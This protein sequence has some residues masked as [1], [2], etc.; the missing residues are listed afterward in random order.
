M[1][2]K[3]R[4]ADAWSDVPI[5]CTQ[6]KNSAVALHA[7]EAYADADA[8]ALQAWPRLGL[9]IW[10]VPVPVQFTLNQ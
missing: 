6:G 10:Q 4:E 7:S 9:N 5:P 8:V 2:E 1:V 3:L